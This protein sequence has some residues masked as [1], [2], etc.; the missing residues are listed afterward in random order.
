[1]A[2]DFI[3]I[4]NIQNDETW[5]SRSIT[6]MKSLLVCPL[7]DENELT[8][9]AFEFYRKHDKFNVLDELFTS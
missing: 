7:R 3:N 4:E 1:M 6:K 2:N 8:I 5:I 9:G